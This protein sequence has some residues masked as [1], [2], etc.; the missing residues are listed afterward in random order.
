MSIY[1]NNHYLHS[2]DNTQGLPP[3]HGITNRDRDLGALARERGRDG[4]GGGK[5]KILL[6]LFGLFGLFC[7]ADLLDGLMDGLVLRG[8]VS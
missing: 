2:R 6:G 1:G 8:V 5:A 3:H 4:D 7:R